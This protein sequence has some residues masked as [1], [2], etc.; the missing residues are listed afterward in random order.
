MQQE[1]FSGY[2]TGTDFETTSTEENVDVLVPALCDGELLMKK[3]ASGY[4]GVAVQS[5]TLNNQPVTVIYGHL[6]LSS[7]ALSAGQ[8]LKKGDLLGVLGKGYSTETDGERKHLHLGIH[9]GYSVNI[10]GYTPKESDLSSW[11]DPT[12]FLK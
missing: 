5:C 4:G 7:I 12:Q 8:V 9:V 10:L 11:L 2:H 3:Y 6:R 1:K